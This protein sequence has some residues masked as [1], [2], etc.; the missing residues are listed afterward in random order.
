[1]LHAIAS[2]ETYVMGPEQIGM[3]MQGSEI[4]LPLWDNICLDDRRILSKHRPDTYG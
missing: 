4:H 3:Y 2:L 1:M